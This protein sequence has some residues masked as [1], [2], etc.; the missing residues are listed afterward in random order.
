M[1]GLRISAESVCFARRNSCPRI[2][3]GIDFMSWMYLGL[4]SDPKS[5][6]RFFSEFSESLSDPVVAGEGARG[7]LL[8][9]L[10]E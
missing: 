3:K 9:I 8:K 6:Y 7:S 5:D 2:F 10:I 1:S 4:L